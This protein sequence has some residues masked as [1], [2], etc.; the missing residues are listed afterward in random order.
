MMPKELSDLARDYLND[1]A[2]LFWFQPYDD[3][4]ALFIEHESGDVTIAS[5]TEGSTEINY[6]NIEYDLRN[7]LAEDLKL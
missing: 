1:G 5:L 7:K 3:D 6:L 4:N 2:K